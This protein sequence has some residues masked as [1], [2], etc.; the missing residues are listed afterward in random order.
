VGMVAVAPEASPCILSISA[1]GYGKRTPLDEYPV[2]RRGGKGVWTM[3]ITPRTGR[4]IAIKAVQDTD[5]L[6]IITQ[7]GLMIRIHVA[8]I[9]RM[10]RHTQGVR[11]IQLKPGDAIADVTRLVTEAQEDEAA[12]VPATV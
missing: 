10:G 3:K 9:S 1:N 8:D 5:D 12:A 4:L 11:L 7:N 2:Q 6:M